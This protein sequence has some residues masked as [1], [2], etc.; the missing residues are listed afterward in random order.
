MLQFLLLFPLFLVHRAEIADELFLV[1]FLVIYV[2]IAEIAR[3]I[4]AISPSGEL[5]IVEIANRAIS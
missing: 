3:A 1:L 2:E 5:E 4:S